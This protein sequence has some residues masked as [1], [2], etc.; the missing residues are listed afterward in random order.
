MPKNLDFQRRYQLVRTAVRGDIEAP[1]TRTL[2]IGGK[3]P[4]G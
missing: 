3:L 4:L 2:D 1:P